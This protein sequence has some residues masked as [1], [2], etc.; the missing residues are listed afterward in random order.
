MFRI[1]SLF[2]LASFPISLMG[3]QPEGFKAR[4]FDSPVREFSVI[5]TEAGYFPDSLFAY[6][7]DKARFFVTSTADAPQC[8]LLKDHNI[9]LAAEKGKMEEGHVEFKYPG[10]FEYYCPS[11]KFKGRITVVERPDAEREARKAKKLKREVAS[12]KKS[13][14]SPRDYD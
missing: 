9:F 1:I 7:G 11:T 3:K 5:A 12:K 8:F 6:V 10:R 14:W 13:Y 4:E 2:L